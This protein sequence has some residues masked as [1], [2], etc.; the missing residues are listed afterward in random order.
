MTPE[1]ATLKD[2]K[3]RQT[4]CRA[5]ML[6]VFNDNPHAL[7]HGDVERS[8][9]EKFD[10]VTVY[11]TLKTFLEKG[12]IHKVLDDEGGTKYAL[13]RD[14]CHAAD[15]QHHHDHVHFKCNRCG[16][17]TCLDDVA[18]PTLSLP[19]GYRREETN[20]LVQGICPTCGASEN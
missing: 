8:L 20:L 11:R 3:L 2:F 10:R 18:V 4:D 19:A 15:H 14:A 6:A 7:A 1:R 12:I 9:P 5:E 17:T 13:C 16:L